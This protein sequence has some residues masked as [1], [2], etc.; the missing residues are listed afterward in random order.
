MSQGA[1]DTVIQPLKK[2][3]LF[4]DALTILFGISSWIGVTSVFLQLPL[5]VSTAPEGW[6]LPSSMAITV[7]T[8]NIG[9]F[10]YVLYQKYSPKKLNDGLLI[11]VTLIIGCIA[12]ICMSFF[13][14]HTV[15]IN[16]THHSVALL[17]FTLMFASVGC[18][19]SVLFMPYMGRFRECYLVTYMFGMG[20]SG[21][22]SSVLALIQGVGGPPECIK[23]N[24][25]DG[26]EFIEYYPPPLFGTKVYF[27]F[28]FAVMVLSTIAFVLLNNLS[29]CKKE[30]AAGTIGTG[31][32][33]HYDHKENSEE[34]NTKIPD[35]V[36]NLS[37]FNYV[38]LMA[39]VV[40]LSGLG[41]GIFPGLITYF[42]LP[43]GNITYHFAVTLA[44]IANPC[45][46]F[47]AMFVPHTSIRVI[48]FLSF[49]GTVIAIYIFVIALQSPDPPLKDST[50]GDIL[51]VSHT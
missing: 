22:L 7:Q 47:I 3:N 12:A 10:A 4:V 51:I 38:Y 30:Y 29:T 11:Y 33:Y 28:V 48:R 35:D 27:E 40:G 46:G 39:V 42:C 32:E 25:T 1:A 23:N 8:A 31:N 49:I 13:Y 19:S 41:N 26:P 9:S 5:L 37:T 43:Y 34:K 2:R 17:L 14:Q 21:F 16:G 44:A 15:E 45:A 36:I 50:L 18:L 24:S 20:L 6:N